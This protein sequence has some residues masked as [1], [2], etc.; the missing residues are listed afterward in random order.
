MIHGTVTIL[1]DKIAA[2]VHRLWMESLVEKK[3]LS[4]S[5]KIRVDGFQQ[6]F[7]ASFFFF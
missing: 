7:Q 4:G 6:G 3:V 5:S 1:L 2:E